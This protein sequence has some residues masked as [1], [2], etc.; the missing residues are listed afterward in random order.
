M[1]IGLHI[2]PG[3]DLTSELALELGNEATRRATFR[4]PADVRSHPE[5]FGAT[6]NGGARG[7]HGGPVGIADFWLFNSLKRGDRT[8]L[9]N[10]YMRV[11]GEA[12]RRYHWAGP[13]AY[14]E[15]RAGR[16]GLTF[17]GPWSTSTLSERAGQRGEH[18]ASGRDS[19]RAQC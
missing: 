6:I 15:F 10:Y 16:P 5:H 2:K 19:E 12:E 14:A 1:W 4:L 11:L 8:K 13:G 9:R 17:H 18:W 7:A 3:G